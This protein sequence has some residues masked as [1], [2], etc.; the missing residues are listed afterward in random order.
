MSHALTC[1]DHSLPQTCARRKHSS[2]G[3]VAQYVQY[4]GLVVSFFPVDKMVDGVFTGAQVIIDGGAQRV[5]FAIPLA[6]L[7]DLSVEGGANLGCWIWGRAGKTDRRECINNDIE[8]RGREPGQ[9]IGPNGSC[10][11]REVLQSF[12]TPRT[13]RLFLRERP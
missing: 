8:K 5:L 7:Q 12:W 2:V 9:T 1:L 10:L 11:L 13:P 6:F 4:I 3:W